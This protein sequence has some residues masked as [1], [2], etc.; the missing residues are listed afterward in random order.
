M[1][2]CEVRVQT[3]FHINIQLS[4]HSLL[5][6]LFFS[7]INCLGTL[8]RNQLTINAMVYFW[9][10]NSIPLISMSFFMPI[11][12]CLDYCSFRV[13]EIGKCETSNFD[14]LFQYYLI[15]LG[16]LYFYRILGSACWNLQQ[17]QQQQISAGIL[18]WIV[19]ILYINLRN[20]VT[21]IILSLVIYKHDMSFHLF[22]SSL[23]Y[24][25]NVL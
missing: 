9:N 8:V 20:N 23:I 10:F 3:S 21:L 24:F 7:S 5:K 22:T 6:R 4:Q 18:I 19:F 12:H 15:I 2:K 14:F 1:Y 16:P 17:Q 11:P 13:F 25:N